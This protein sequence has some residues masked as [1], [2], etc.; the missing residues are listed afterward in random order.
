MM[1]SLARSDWPQL[2]LIALA[3]L[4][5]LPFSLRSAWQLTALRFGDERAASFGVNTQRLRRAALLRISTLAAIAVSLTGVIGFI[6]LIAPPLPRPAWAEDRPWYLA[7]SALQ[8]RVIHLAASF[9]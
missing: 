9:P 2:G 4:V 5:V 1:G 6:A 7:A 8:G 3:L